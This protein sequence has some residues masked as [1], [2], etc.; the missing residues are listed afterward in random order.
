MLTIA[1]YIFHSHCWLRDLVIFLPVVSTQDRTEMQVNKTMSQSM[2]GL[3][4]YSLTSQ[5]EILYKGRCII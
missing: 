4:I 3:C 1:A 2:R 5:L